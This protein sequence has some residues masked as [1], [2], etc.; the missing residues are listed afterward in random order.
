MLGHGKFAAG[1]EKFDLFVPATK[2]QL[3]FTKADS[4]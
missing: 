4:S 1:T 3:S 2:Q